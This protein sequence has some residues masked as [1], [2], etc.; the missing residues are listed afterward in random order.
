MFVK[1]RMTLNPVTTTETTPVLEAGE[2]MRK[3]NFARLPVLRDGKLVGIIT[4]DDL[5]KVS[6]SSASTLSV[7]ELNYL[8]SKLS[9]KDAMTKNVF[10]VKPDVTLEEAA[11]LMR[12][13]G[14]GALPVV[15]SGKL[16]G[17]ITESDIF[18]AF[19]DLM[20]LK[21]TGTRLTLD[22]EDRIGALADLTEI[23]KKR[24]VNI[25]SMAL[26]HV[27]NAGEVVLRLDSSKTDDLIKELQAKGYKVLHI[28]KWN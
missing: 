26:F 22:L 6:P 21:L 28:A 7:W 9:V 24:G 14:V 5:L 2:I 10:T 12:E 3:N 16:L 15:D 8:L 11:L 4:R 23:L 1:D 19:L 20:G 18:D 27:N 25:I 13:K 17:I